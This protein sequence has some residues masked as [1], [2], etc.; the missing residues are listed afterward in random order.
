MLDK[1]LLSIEGKTCNP[2]PLVHQDMIKKA[3]FYL[4]IN[5]E[6]IKVIL[7]AYELIF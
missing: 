6:I 1:W 4:K 7:C 3:T 2:T 5:G